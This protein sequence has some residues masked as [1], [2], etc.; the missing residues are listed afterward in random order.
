[1]FCFKQTVLANVFSFSCCSS[2]RSPLDTR[3]IIAAQIGDAEQILAVKGDAEQHSV[4]RLSIRIVLKLHRR[5]IMEL[6]TGT[7]T[8]DWDSS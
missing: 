2:L 7:V 4:S 6:G 5:S 3:A 1:M 8:E